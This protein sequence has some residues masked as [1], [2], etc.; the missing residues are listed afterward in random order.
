MRGDADCLRASVIPWVGGWG[1]SEPGREEQRDCVWTLPDGGPWLGG[2]R[3]IQI[4]QESSVWCFTSGSLPPSLSVDM[5]ST[6]GSHRHITDWSRPAH[7]GHLSLGAELPCTGLWNNGDAEGEKQEAG[8]QVG[9]Q[10]RILRVGDALD[11]GSPPGLMS[12]AQGRLVRETMA[13]AVRLQAISLVPGSVSL[14]SLGVASPWWRCW[15]GSLHSGTHLR[16][17]ASPT[18]PRSWNRDPQELGVGDRGQTPSS[19][20]RP[21]DPRAR[22]M[23][24]WEPQGRMVNRHHC[25]QT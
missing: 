11:T 19:S 25:A 1:D 5:F 23:V 2:L 13:L 18:R 9:G 15:V 24:A 4:K 6:G 14:S 21:T 20:S 10:G 16:T 3:G 17:G 8:H 7:R 22:R 12:G